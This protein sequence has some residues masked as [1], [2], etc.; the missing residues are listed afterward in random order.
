MLRRIILFGFLLPAIASWAWAASEGQA[1]LDR[2][3]SLKLNAKKQ[4]DLADVIQLC[5]S[6][7]DKGLDASNERFAKN[8]LASSLLER[9]TL[10]ADAVFAAGVNDPLWR[11]YRGMALDDLEKA[12]KA[13]PNLPDAYLLIARLNLLPDGDKKRAAAA[14]DSALAVEGVRLP[15]RAQLLLLRAEL[16]QDNQKKLQLLDAV[17][18]LLPA[19]PGPLR[20]RASILRALGKNEQALADMAKLIE[21]APDEVTLYEEQAKALADLKRYD[22]ALVSLDKAR[23]FAPHSVVP[24]T[25]RAQIH[26]QMN[27]LDAALHDLDQA[28]SLQPGNPFVLMLRAHLYHE[29]D[30]PEAALAD[31]DKA[32]H[33]RPD[34]EQARRLRWAVLIGQ[35][36]FDQ[37]IADME[38]RLKDAPDD[39]DVLIQMAMLY[40]VRRQPQKAIDIYSSILAKAPDNVEALAGRANALLGIGKHAEAVADYDKVMKLD[41]NDSGTLNNLA[42][43]LATSP[44]DALRDG[45]RA[46]ELA[47]KA[48]KLTDHKQAHILS[49]LAAAHA[50]TGDFKTA[51]EWSKKAIELGKKGEE[52]EV[53][54]SLKKELKSYEAGK[55]WRERLN[56]GL[57]PGPQ[58]EPAAKKSQDAPAASDK[59]PPPGAAPPDASGATPDP[60]GP[61]QEPG[62]PE[63]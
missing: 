41:A 42:W 59:A 33:E 8:L 21:M 12:V 36:K 26:V 56:E 63:L 3:M 23:Q 38:Q 24:L 55:P 34:F 22:Q 57:Q 20:A 60:S 61:P 28:V 51:V 62:L 14:L 47:T 44:E 35:R 27:N 48:C 45:R 29:M 10:A 9:A 4:S 37:V 11:N 31:L 19:S 50:E 6:A 18:K 15:I 46:I 54:E 5:Q 58:K 39:Q 40:T 7:L 53:L 2:A 52:P 1:D 49:T 13:V 16:E 25:Y 32:L 30:K 43:V 17:V